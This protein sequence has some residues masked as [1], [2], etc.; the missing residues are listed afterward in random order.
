MSIIS[1]SFFY[2]SIHLIRAFRC[3]TCLL[4]IGVQNPI[5]TI[6]LLIRVFFL[7][8]LLLFFRQREYFSRLF[9]IVYV[10]AIV[11]LFLFIIR[12][13][14]IKRVNVAT[15]FR[16]LLSYRYLLLGFFIFEVLF[17]RKWDFFDLSTFFW[18]L[19]SNVHKDQFPLF[20]EANFYPSWADV[21]FQ[22]NHLRALGAVLFTQNNITL[23]LAAILLFLSRV[24]ALAVTLQQSEDFS[25]KNIFY[26]EKISSVKIQDQN[27]QAL[28]NKFIPLITSRIK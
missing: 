7:G 15:Q 24:G 16:G 2:I 13:L 23:I 19:Q 6:L 9:L 28:R 12:R 22:L 1:S 11:V 14:E 4:V 3:G 25:N 17:F 10:G 18:E 27:I 5:H 20:I 8:T 26:I 21:L